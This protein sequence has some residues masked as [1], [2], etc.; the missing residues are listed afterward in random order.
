MNPFEMFL[1]RRVSP[2]PEEYYSSLIAYDQRII[3]CFPNTEKFLTTAEVIVSNA[4]DSKSPLYNWAH[5]YLE[6][7]VTKGNDI[8]L[9]VACAI[10]E[11]TYSNTGFNLVREEF[12]S[13]YDISEDAASLITKILLKNQK[14]DWQEISSTIKSKWQTRPSLNNSAYFYSCA[15]MMANPIYESI[16]QIVARLIEDCLIN[17]MPFLKAAIT[18]EAVFDG[19]KLLELITEEGRFP[20]FA[21]SL[22]EVLS[23]IVIWERLYKR[24]GDSIDKRFTDDTVTN[25]KLI[26]A[27]QAFA[28]HLTELAPDEREKIVTIFTK[29]EDKFGYLHLRRIIS[30]RLIELTPTC[31]NLAK[32]LI[33]GL[34]FDGPINKISEAAIEALPESQIVSILLFIANDGHHDYAKNIKSKIVASVKANPTIFQQAMAEVMNSGLALTRAV[35]LYL[36]GVGFEFT[37]NEFI[38]WLNNH[39]FYAE[40]Y[41]SI[42]MLVAKYIKPNNLSAG[43]MILSCR[44]VLLEMGY[45]LKI[46]DVNET[47]KVEKLLCNNAMSSHSSQSKEEIEAIWRNPQWRDVLLKH[48]KCLTHVLTS[49]VENSSQIT[50]QKFNEVIGDCCQNNSDF[51]QLVCELAWTWLGKPLRNFL[52]VS[53]GLNWPENNIDEMRQ[54]CLT[55]WLGMITK[56]D[57]TEVCQAVLSKSELLDL[58][59]G[60]KI[61]NNNSSS[62]YQIFS[63]PERWSFLFQGKTKLDQLW[64]HLIRNRELIGNG[65]WL[66]WIEFYDFDKIPRITREFN[67]IIND[68]NTTEQNIKRTLKLLGF[69]E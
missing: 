22:A 45:T 12:L 40:D 28:S 56:D 39:H 17:E 20:I 60:L 35:L 38:N 59:L 32:F 33:K 49:F 10:R 26:K 23:D 57:E 47:I 3:E 36:E 65:L 63:K 29:G 27:I 5:G 19:D 44:R 67:K 43:Q 37:K 6:Q 58:F 52:V 18:E 2:R 11:A 31:P 9:F 64:S 68:P 42:A 53:N 69:E 51:R 34:D 25:P 13:R 66:S 41:N 14:P 16:P 7:L 24:A 62:N 21:E 54:Y 46:Q 4:I 50:T 55:N 30:G 48:G 1:T 8:S 15:R 61:K